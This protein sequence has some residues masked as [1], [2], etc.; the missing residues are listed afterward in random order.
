MNIHIVGLSKVWLGWKLKCFKGIVHP[1]M[2]I[3]IIYS[4]SSFFVLMNTKDDILKNVSS[5]HLL[6]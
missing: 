1:K 3:V 6:A 2:N 4:P 5:P